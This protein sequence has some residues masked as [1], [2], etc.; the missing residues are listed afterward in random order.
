MESMDY[1]RDH[2]LA[3]ISLTRSQNDPGLEIGFPRETA[4]L[5]FWLEIKSVTRMRDVLT[6]THA[7]RFD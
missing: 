6:S 4:E 5:K 7:R 3:T 2:Y 1:P